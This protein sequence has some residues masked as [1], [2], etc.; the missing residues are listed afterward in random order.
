MGQQVDPLAE[1]RA[2]LDTGAWETAHAA[3]SACDRATLTAADLDA[4]AD[5]AWWTS[6]LDESIELRQLAHS[7]YLE[8]GE[9]LRAAYAAWLLYFDYLEKGMSG[10]A[11]GW[12]QRARRLLEPVPESAEHGYLAL[13]DSG[14]LADK[15]DLSGSREAIERALEIGRRTDDRALVAMA[16]QNLGRNLIAAGAMSEGIALLD[17]A[18]TA[19][20]ADGLPPLFTGWIFCDVLGACLQVADLG[21]AGEWSDAALRWCAARNVTRSFHGLC[22]LY[23][24]QV[25]TAHGWWDEAETEAGRASDYLASLHPYLSGEALYT[26]GEIRRRRGDFTGAERMFAKAHGL[27]REPQPGLA[28]VRLAQGKTTSAAGALQAALRDPPANL[29]DRSR[30]LSAAVEIFLADGN[31]E[32]ARSC[33]TELDRLADPAQSPLLT[34]TADAANGAM[35]F[36]SGDPAT[37][38]ALLR[39]AWALWQDLRLPYEAARV[40]ILMGRAN[41]ADGNEER[42]R[43]E[44]E[45]G[46]EELERLGAAYDAQEARALLQRRPTAAGLSSREVEILRLVAS[47]RTNREIATEL[48]LSAH[49]V[50]RHVHNIYTKVGVSSRAAATAFAFEHDLV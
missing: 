20:L 17:E 1:A 28:L 49:T 32:A 11:S 36:A 29:I 5:A 7:R 40:R 8:Q 23:R 25:T 35:A 2:A 42:A 9:A 47:G 6:R 43:L 4:A 27:G 41:R 46:L 21:R 18:M 14:V 10:S 13:A 38:I 33:C 26:L 50:V 45:A 34:A 48:S 37:A 16:I 12:L 39:R 22:L 44:I 24:L 31:P 3:F 19:A 15:G 30:L